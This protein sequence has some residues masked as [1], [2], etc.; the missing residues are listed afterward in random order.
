MIDIPRSAM[1]HQIH[2]GS[3]HPEGAQAFLKTDRRET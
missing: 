3:R 2:F 1:A